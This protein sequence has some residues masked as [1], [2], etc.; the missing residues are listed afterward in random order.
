MTNRECSFIG[1]TRP[2]KYAADGLCQSHGR[3]R[4]RGEVLRPLRQWN[5]RKVAVPDGER[6]CSGC[7]EPKPDADFYAS[8]NVAD[9]MS[10]Q[11]KTC[12]RFGNVKSKYGITA[13]QY[14]ALWNAQGGVCAICKRECPTGRELAV[15]HDHACCSGTKSCGFCVVALLCGPCNTGIG[16]LG[17]DPERIRAAADYVEETRFKNKVK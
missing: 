11:C 17:D 1:C 16:Q 10:A 7:R 8:A 2:R 6:V 4:D 15:D 13:D 12:T 9:G 5:S 3:Q 14:M